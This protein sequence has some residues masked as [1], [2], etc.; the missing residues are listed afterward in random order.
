MEIK[1]R[2]ERGN[3]TYWRTNIGFEEWNKYDENNIHTHYRN[4]DDYGWYLQNG[5]KVIFR[6]KE[7]K[8]KVFRKQEQEF[9]SREEIPI[10]ELMEL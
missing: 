7:L 6:G 4:S 5:K 1:K 10:F 8:E 9:L 2:D 3:I